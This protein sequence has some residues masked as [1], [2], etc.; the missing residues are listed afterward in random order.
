MR[1][2]IRADTSGWLI[3]HPTLVGAT[4][5]A[6]SRIVFCTNSPMQEAT[7]IGLEGAK[8]HNFFPDQLKAYEERRDILCSY[9]DELG[10]SY[11]RP[12]GSYFLLVDMDP[13]KVP[14]TFETPAFCT[15]GGRGRDFA[16]CWW[17]AQEIGVV[18]IP[19]S[20]VSFTHIGASELQ[21][22]PPVL[23][24]GARADRRAL[25]PLRIRTFP[26][27]FTVTSLMGLQ[28]KD[29]ELLH[30]AGQ[31]LLRLKEFIDPTQVVPRKRKANVGV[32]GA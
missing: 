8:E 7:A 26:S 30:K 6:H 31:R 29:P 12:D 32:N 10:L 16:K 27:F 20:E 24:Q 17:L 4:L 11:T 13:V 19:P 1:V 14:D 18:G 21:P 15:E 25:R 3:G 2:T 9:F 22:D 23:L 28:C 5:A